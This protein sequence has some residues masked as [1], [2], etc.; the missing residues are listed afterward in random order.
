MRLFG[1]NLT[2]GAALNC[3]ENPIAVSRFTFITRVRLRLLSI[4]NYRRVFI[5]FVIHIR[6]VIMLRSVDNEHE[7]GN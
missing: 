1:L 2:S 3:C 5:T 6:A 4:L 7:I